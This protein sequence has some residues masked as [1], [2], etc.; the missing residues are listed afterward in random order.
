MFG[1]IVILFALAVAYPYKEVTDEAR[2]DMDCSNSS[3]S[4]Y[5]KANCLILDI[6]LPLLIGFFI[7]LAGAVIG[8][9]RWL[10]MR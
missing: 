4:D 9:I 10:V 8:G 1:I 6:N 3:I 5:D 2:A 7:F